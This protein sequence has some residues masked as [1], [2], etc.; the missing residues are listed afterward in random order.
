MQREGDLIVPTDDDGFTQ[1]RKNSYIA[2]VLPET[3]RTQSIEE[4]HENVAY[5]S[6]KNCP[7]EDLK[8]MGWLCAILHDCGKLCVDFQNYMEAVL[9]FGSEVRRRQIDHSTA[10]GRIIENLDSRSLASKMISTAIYSHHGLQDCINMNGHALSEERGSKLI[11]FEMI[12]ERYSTL[13]DKS[14]LENRFSLA[15]ADLEQIRKRIESVVKEH[16]DNVYGNKRFFLGMYQRLLLS[17]LIDSDW[18]D[19]ASFSEEIPLP[20][21]LST[22]QTQMI[23]VQSIINFEQYLNQLSKKQNHKGKVSPLNIYRQEISDA[24]KAAA[25]DSANLYRLTVPTGAGKTLSSL[26]FALYHARKFKKKHIIYVA[27]FNSILEQNAR[28]IRQAVGNDKVV[29]EHHCNIVHE[30]K[31][32]DREYRK[33]TESWDSPIIVT[34]AVQLLNTLFSDKKCSIR[35]MYNICNSVIIF[36]EVQAFPVTCTE[37]FNLAVNFLTAFCNTTVI[38]CSATQPSLAILEENRVFDSGE[39]AGDVDKYA[40]VFKRT[41]ILDKTSSRGMEIE[42]LRNFVEEIFQNQKSILIIVNTKSCARSIYETLKVSCGDECGLYH[43]STN[44][45]AKNRQNELD[46]VKESLNAKKPVICVSTQLVEAGVDF[47]FEC[48]IRSMAGLDSV[49]QAAGRCNRHQECKEH[50]IVY[51]VRMS[52]NAEKL[53]SLREIRIAQDALNVV[54][55]YYK[56]KPELF[57]G[58]LDS[59]KAIGFYYKKYFEQMIPGTTKYPV[60]FEGGI[61]TNLVNLL[62]QNSLGRAQFARRHGGK[63]PKSM[64]IQ[65]FKQAGKMFQVIPNDQKVEVAVPYDNESKKSIEIL[66]NP[67]LPL[68]DKRVEI[69]KLQVYSVGISQQTKDKLNNAIYGICDGTVLVLN[70]SYYDNKVGVLDYPRLKEMLF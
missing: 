4:H 24:C 34:T 17:L 33:L 19:T 47:S 23:W 54:L 51:I 65:A 25:E 22:E 12:S 3:K 61:A 48:V 11:D 46:K 39:L 13:I 15:K 70:D 50:G 38:L 52:L 6:E 8:N 55:D 40:N 7:L 18:S 31:E 63:A 45:C 53:G 14:I 1:I 60:A 68:A 16:G 64:L 41:V 30:N 32:D 29:L 49:I 57:D 58:R 27:P 56:K 62:S 66:S 67:Y 26:R 36:D 20:E 43:L 9:E 37:L 10:G 2:H 21:R 59:Q 5:L 35:R 44:M 42:D 28:D 69:R